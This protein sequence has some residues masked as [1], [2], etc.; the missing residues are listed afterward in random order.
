MK[1]KVLAG[2]AL[3]AL[4]T[5]PAFALSP[6]ALTSPS[7]VELAQ[8]TTKKAKPKVVKKVDV[9]PKRSK[10]EECMATARRSVTHC[11]KVK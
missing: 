10:F 8:A 9:A 3:A 6:P 2:I 1:K 7:A 5:A 4:M 11:G